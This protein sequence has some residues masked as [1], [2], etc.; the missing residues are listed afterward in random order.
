M[1]LLRCLLLILLL[2]FFAVAEE[3]NILA[4]RDQYQNIKNALPGMT[5]HEHDLAGYS[6]EGGVCIAYRDGEQNLRYIEVFFFGESGK[7]TYEFYLAN[8]QPFFI[9]ATD[10]RYNAPLA[11]DN[12]FAQE[13]E[14][15]V[16]D[17]KKTQVF[18][19]R[20]Y[21]DQGRLIRWLDAENQ[22]V[23]L[24]SPQALEKKAQLA[25]IQE[26]VFSN[27]Q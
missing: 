21:Y 24:N 11:W 12:A 26:I 5:A 16:F 1:K 13:L 6:S 8:G 14:A 2:P 18:A 17:P 10:Y 25:E 19:S 4:I 15:E 9:F 7:A 27:C 22:P 23:A 3:A 20:Y